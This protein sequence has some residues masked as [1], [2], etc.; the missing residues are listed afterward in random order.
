MKDDDLAVT[1]AQL[2]RVIGV[3]KQRIGQYHAEGLPKAGR[4]L[5]SLPA[6]FEW[7][8]ERWETRAA[9]SGSSEELRKAQTEKVELQNAIMRAELIPAEDF[10]AYLHDCI[11]T[12][13]TGFDNA[14]SYFDDP[15]IRDAIRERHDDIRVQLRAKLESLAGDLRSG[16]FTAAATANSTRR[17]GRKVSNHARR[18]AKA[19]A[20]E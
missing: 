10:R 1:T 14:E 6:V 20:V 15:N 17:V 11:A 9:L 8:R 13:L 7:F 2:A 12:L 5:W 4:D 18:R 3:N 16:G 19:G